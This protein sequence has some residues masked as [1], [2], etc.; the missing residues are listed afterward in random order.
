MSNSELQSLSQM[1]FT[2]NKDCRSASFVS[3][4][5]FFLYLITSTSDSERISFV[6]NLFHKLCLHSGHTWLNCFAISSLAG[7]CCWWRWGKR[8]EGVLSLSCF[9][10][11]NCENLDPPPPGAAELAWFDMG[12]FIWRDTV[13]GSVSNPSSLRRF[14]RPGIESSCRISPR[15]SP[16]GPTWCVAG[17]SSTTDKCNHEL[18]S[19]SS[20]F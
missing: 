8:G 2:Q 16:P 18:K 3:A 19:Q 11:K 5:V 15:M 6:K 13:G 17:L 10:W 9:C 14:A 20:L 12:W 7:G 1:E 4:M